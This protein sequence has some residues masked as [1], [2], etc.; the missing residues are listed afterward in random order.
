MAM[1]YNFEETAWKLLEGTEDAAKLWCLQK[2]WEIIM[3]WGCEA[4]DPNVHYIV[5]INYS[6]YLFFKQKRVP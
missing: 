5:E 1:Y 3:C 4:I 6:S 2:Y